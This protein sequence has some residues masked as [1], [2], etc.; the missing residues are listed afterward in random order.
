MDFKQLEALIAI[1]DYGSF[2]SAGVA[3]NTAQSNISTRIKNL[4]EELGVTLID[5]ATTTLTAAGEAV[6]LRARRIVAEEHA[7]GADVLSLDTQVTGDVSIGMIGTTGRWLVPRILELQ[8]TRYPLVRLRI[9]EGTNS[10]LE[11]RIRSGQLD[12]G[13]LSRPSDTGAFR[14]EAL[15]QE[16]LVLVAPRKGPG[17]FSE[18][19]VTLAELATQP[20]LLPLPGTPLREDVDE[21]ARQQGVTLSPIIEMDGVRTLAS[22]AFDRLGP[23]ILPATAISPHLADEFRGTTIEGLR[24]RSVTMV[25][26]RYGLPSAAVRSIRELIRDVLADAA[27]LPTGLHRDLDSNGE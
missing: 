6:T 1:A 12:M 10:S 18:P 16:D 24:P 7:I 5:R 13:I 15:F 11:P 3:L 22:L 19:S 21:A 25:L 17:S 27:S 14:V 23:A 2:S 20:L 4:E 26:P 8:R 9:V